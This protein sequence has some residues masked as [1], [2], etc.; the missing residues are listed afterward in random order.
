MTGVRAESSLAG[1]RR[2]APNKLIDN[3]GISVDRLP[4]LR[5]VFDRMIAALSERV[6]PMTAAPVLFSVKEI[7]SARI[8]DVLED[9][10]GDVIGAVFIVPEWDTRIF[11]CLNRKFLNILLEALFGGSGEEWSSE[12]RPFSGA[13]HR[14]AQTILE[15]TAK[16]FAVSF[17]SVVETSLQFEGIE[18][19]MEFVAIGRRNNFA[20]VATLEFQSLGHSGEI[21]LLIPQQGFNAIRPRLERDPA[22]ENSTRDPRWVKQLRGKLGR[23]E[24][25]L[26]AVI[27]EHQ[28][29]LKDISLLRVGEILPLQATPLSK[30]KLE[31]HDQTLFWCKLGQAEG[32]Y[33]VRLEESVD[34]EREFIDDILPD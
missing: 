25:S 3:G 28:F 30:L 13:D 22:E 12:D 7:G 32:H 11:I 31:C 27:E 6:R 17:S 20:V 18:S 5:V 9:C 29:T 10:D 24:V 2:D 15:H 1:S 21:R 4:M 8:S 19:R 33:T 26:R 14:I 34:Q 23:T 16:S